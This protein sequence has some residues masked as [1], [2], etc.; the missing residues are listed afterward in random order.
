MAQRRAL[1]LRRRSRSIGSHP[2]AVIPIEL[3]KAAVL[4]IC[5]GLDQVWPSCLMAE[6]IV[7]RD[8][9]LYGPR[10]EILSYLDA[11]H[12]VFSSPLQPGEKPRR[13][14]FG[15]PA[16]RNTAAQANSWR[17]AIAFLKD[18]PGASVAVGGGRAS[19]SYIAACDISA[20]QQGVGRGA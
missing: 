1:D 16:R 2:A 15:P 14:G 4:L 17:Q 7:A 8:R 10:I 12:C 18:T 3:S 5:G 6:Q 9:K 19:G 11:D 13:F 20:S